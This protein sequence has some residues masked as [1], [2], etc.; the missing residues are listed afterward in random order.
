MTLPSVSCKKGSTS[1]SFLGRAWSQL[2]LSDTERQPGTFHSLLVCP[3]RNTNLVYLICLRDFLSSPALCCLCALGVSAPAFTLFDGFFLAVVIL[4]LEILGQNH[5]T[6]RLGRKIFPLGQHRPAPWGNPQR[7]SHHGLLQLPLQAPEK[8]AHLGIST[9]DSACAVPDR[10]CKCGVDLQ[11]LF[12]PE[13]HPDSISWLS[14]KAFCSRST[15]NH[16]RTTWPPSSHILSVTGEQLLE[17]K[18]QCWVDWDCS[19]WKEL[20]QK[21]PC[22]S[23]TRNTLQGA[24]SGPGEIPSRTELKGF[25]EQREQ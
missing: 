9:F 15:P 19:D 10:L 4:C 14:E 20:T 25:W 12:T 2:A 17:E 5:P 8:K 23:A 3:G 13:L 7:P 11:T 16:C 24:R 18:K 6:G 22:V 21:K 1:K